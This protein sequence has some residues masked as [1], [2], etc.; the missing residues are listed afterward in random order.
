MKSRRKAWCRQ[1]HDNKNNM[2][3]VPPYIGAMK[4]PAIRL[5]L[6]AEMPISRKVLISIGKPPYIQ[7][8]WSE[9][10]RVLFIGAATEEALLSFKVQKRYYE[11]R[12]GFKIRNIQFIQ[13]IMKIAGWDENM[14]CVVKGEYIPKL[15]MMAFRLDDADIMDVNLEVEVDSDE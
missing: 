8:W 10:Q 4:Q 5:K 2:A 12:S 1:M 6:G 13:T 3:V 9:S 15:N 11:T 14:I 7:F